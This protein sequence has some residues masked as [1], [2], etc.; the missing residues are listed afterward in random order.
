MYEEPEIALHIE[1][2]WLD[3][4]VGLAIQP[5]GLADPG[6]AGTHSPV[7]LGE[8]DTAS[9]IRVGS[10]AGNATFSTTGF[11]LEAEDMRR[12]V[13]RVEPDKTGQRCDLVV[14]RSIRPSP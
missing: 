14:A 8:G 4:F 7:E 2:H 12:V 10:I 6:S 1:R 3:D 11:G 9:Q 5:E 13:S